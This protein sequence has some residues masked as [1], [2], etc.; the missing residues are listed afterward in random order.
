MTVLLSS[1][2]TV[3]MIRIKAIQQEPLIMLVFPHKVGYCVGLDK[4][5]DR[6]TP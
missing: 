1:I 3:H 5:T 4:Q 6:Q 2:H